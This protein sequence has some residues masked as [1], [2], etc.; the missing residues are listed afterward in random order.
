MLPMHRLEL[1]EVLPGAIATSVLWLIAAALFTLYLSRLADYGATY[2]TLGGVVITLVFFYISAVIFIYGAEFN[3]S[4]YRWRAKNAPKPARRAGQGGA[5]AAPRP[6]PQA[7]NVATAQPYRWEMGDGDS[8]PP[9]ERRLRE[10][11][12]ENAQLRKQVAAMERE[13]D[14][15]K[16]R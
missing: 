14:R 13:R 4:L 8:L 16:D 2:G 10:L 15:P 5:R 12:E 1:R 6:S 9:G 3:A 7:Q 11:E